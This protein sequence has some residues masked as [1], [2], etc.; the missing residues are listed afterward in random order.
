L[1]VI[2]A[3]QFPPVKKIL[4]AIDGSASSMRAVDFVGDY[5][6]GSGYEVCLFHV[7]RGFD[8]V[9]SEDFDCLMPVDSVEDAKSLMYEIFDG[10]KK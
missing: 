2:I 7:I 10:L 4:I 1:P 9:V 3:G 5:L 6:G 8:N